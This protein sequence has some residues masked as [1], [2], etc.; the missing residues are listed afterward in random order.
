MSPSA[1]P[2][3]SAVAFDIQTAL[4]HVTVEIGLGISCSHALFANDPSQTV[5]AGRMLISIPRFSFAIGEADGD[6]AAGAPAM[7]VAAV[8]G[9]TPSCTHVC[10]LVSKSAPPCFADQDRKSTR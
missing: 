2:S 9:T 6:F 1:T 4:S 7:A 3:L 8:F 5:A 10:Q